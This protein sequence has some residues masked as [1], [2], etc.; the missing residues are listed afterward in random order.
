MGGQCLA[1]PL[2]AN[3]VHFE[4]AFA[5]RRLLA[6]LEGAAMALAVEGHVATIGLAGTEQGF[7]QAHERFTVG[8]M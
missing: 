5:L 8:L 2:W 4:P 3:I 1:E 6:L 7:E